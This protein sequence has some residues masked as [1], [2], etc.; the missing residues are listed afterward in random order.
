MKSKLAALLKRHKAEQVKPDMKLMQQ[1]IG[2]ARYALGINHLPEDKPAVCFVFHN[3]DAGP[4]HRVLDGSQQ[5][6]D[7]NGPSDALNNISNYGLENP[8]QYSRDLYDL[9]HYAEMSGQNTSPTMSPTMAMAFCIKGQGAFEK[10]ALSAGRAFMSDID[11]SNAGELSLTLMYLPAL[12]PNAAPEQPY[13]VTFTPSLNPVRIMPKVSEEERQAEPELFGE[14][15]QK[16]WD[17]VQGALK[18]ARGTFK[19][20]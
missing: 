8:D 11:R 20:S 17:V 12:V 14:M 6:D 18:T 2:D 5:F 15:G 4:F 1:G 16:A 7:A 9:A 3:N 13:Q 19:P 10:L